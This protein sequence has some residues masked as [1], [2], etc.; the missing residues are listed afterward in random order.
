MVEVTR[1]GAD[2]SSRPQSAREE[3]VNSVVH[4]AALLASVA[5]IP[6]LFQLTES[7]PN[8]AV[9]IAGSVVFAATLVL[10][11][12]CSTLYHALPEGRARQL[13]LR[14]DHGAIYLFIAGSFTPFAAASL[15]AASG[16]MLLALVWLLAAIGFTLKVCGRLSHPLVSTG[17]YLL[18]GWMVLTIAAPLIAR[19]PPSAMSWLIAGGLAYTVGVVFFVLDARLR[20]AHAIWHG[21]VVAGTS[22]H[23]V[24]VLGLSH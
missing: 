14:L 9:N 7:T 10:L 11:Y 13:L 17:L 1:E 20:Y 12:L 2:T 19:L 4:G 6:F 3:V 22:C 15:D 21:F 23:F 16:W 24:T 5:A 8:R 18:I